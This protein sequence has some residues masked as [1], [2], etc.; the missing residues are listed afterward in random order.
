ML[1]SIAA[2]LMNVVCLMRSPAITN[3]LYYIY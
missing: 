2:S 1:G 3:L